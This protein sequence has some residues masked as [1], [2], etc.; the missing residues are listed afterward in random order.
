[1]SKYIYA[2]V[3][4][5]M[6]SYANAASVTNP[7]N[8]A[9]SIP[10]AKNGHADAQRRWSAPSILALDQTSSASNPFDGEGIIVGVCASSAPAVAW[11]ASATALG[12]VVIRDSDTVNATGAAIHYQP[13][14][15]VGIAPADVSNAEQGP[16]LEFPDGIPFTTG[17]VAQNSNASMSSFI[18]YRKLKVP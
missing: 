2:L 1:M 4:A 16:C 13:A 9:F 14:R 17:L 5:A 7:A 3:F 18:R 10:E 6:A 11:D 15:N 8:G 12:Y